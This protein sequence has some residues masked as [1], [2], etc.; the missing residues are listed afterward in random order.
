[1][2]MATSCIPAVDQGQIALT[3]ALFCLEC[4]LIFSGM[5]CCPRCAGETIWSLAEWVPPLHSGTTVSK[6]EG[7]HIDTSQSGRSMGADS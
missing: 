4:E 7:G 3:R 2:S 5:S 1:M 6:W